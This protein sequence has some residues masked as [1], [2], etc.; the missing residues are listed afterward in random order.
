VQDDCAECRAGGSGQHW[1]PPSLPGL[2]GQQHAAPHRCPT[3]T[4][5]HCRQV[6]PAS[7]PHCLTASLPHCLT[8]AR[9][10]LPH[11]LTAS[12]PHCLTASL[13]HC[14]TASLPPGTACCSA[15]PARPS[16]WLAGASS[17]SAGPGSSQG[18]AWRWRWR[19]RSSWA[20]GQQLAGPHV[21]S[22]CMASC[23]MSLCSLEADA[24]CSV[25][26][27]CCVQ[28]ALSVCEPVDCWPLLVEVVRSVCALL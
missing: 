3:L 17:P 1:L 27:A 11:C 23:C 7:L 6:R 13:P 15:T 5:P 25:G 10:G 9:Y 26:H 18:S 4:L 21:C 20:G 2:P 24:Q 19:T 16:A 8:A 22:T 14:L 12:L 28:L